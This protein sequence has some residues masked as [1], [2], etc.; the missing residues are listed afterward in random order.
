M[1]LVTEEEKENIVNMQNV[2]KGSIHI[3]YS[4]GDIALADN[5]RELPNAKSMQL[6]MIIVLVCSKGR[7]QLDINGK[8]YLV[9]ANE[10]LFC[11]H[12]NVISNYMISPDF[13][14][15]IICLSYPLMQRILH[16]DRNVW[17]RLYY[18]EQ[19]PVQAI[20]EEEQHLFHDFYELAV[21]M[22]S[23]SIRI[24]HKEVMTGIIQSAL[25]AL[26]GGLKDIPAVD[27]NILCQPDQLYRRFKELLAQDNGL[28]RGV[29]YYAQKLC[30]T[31]KYLTVVCKQKGGHP[32]LE[33][34]RESTIERIRYQLKNSDKSIKEIATELD[35]P[36]LSFFGTFVKQHL[37]VSPK[38]YRKS[39][40]SKE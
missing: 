33:M 34:I 4:D 36:N 25:Y 21:T 23:R 9:K 40:T 26:L 12:Y 7:V 30:I 15:K 18:L 35:F 13:E 16:A 38:V 22:L 11:S 31:S 32:A 39:L 6:D 19:N 10:K 3:D 37:G 27:N 24:Y 29:D 20:D 1:S 17:N 8:Q 5:V 28:H 2:S 14:S